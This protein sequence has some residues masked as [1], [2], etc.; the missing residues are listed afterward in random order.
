MADVAS[1]SFDVDSSPLAQASSRLDQL[2]QSAQAAGS[3]SSQLLGATDALVAALTRSTAAT[4]ALTAQLGQVQAAGTRTSQAIQQVGATAGAATGNVVQLG[5]AAGAT[6]AGFDAAAA[7]AGRL[8][9]AWAELGAQGA[10]TLANLERMQKLAAASASTPGFSPAANSNGSGGGGAAGGN[11]RSMILDN[12]LFQGKDFFEQSITGGSP[13]RAALTG[14]RQRLTDEIVLTADFSSTENADG[15]SR[16]RGVELEFG[17]SPS[18][19]LNLAA[20]YAFLH[21]E[22]QRR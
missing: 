19:R 18:E 10:A 21:A 14:Y 12:I 13:F 17:W 3:K 16:R 9:T 15:R 20:T 22:E 2:G 6:R 8:R 11:Y 7:A 5:N 4:D 1:L